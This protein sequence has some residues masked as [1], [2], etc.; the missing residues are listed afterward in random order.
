M[1]VQSE[2]VEPP[3]APQCDPQPTGKINKAAF[4][5][6]GKRRTGSG[7]ASF[8]SFRNKGATNS[9]S[10]G[11]SDNG[12]SLNGNGSAA[13]LV[14]SKT[15]DGLIGSNNDTD[16][17]RGDGLASLEVGPVR[18]LSKSL[19]FFSLLRRGSFRSSEN[20]GSGLV[21]RGRGLKG[22]FSSMRWR[23]K[24]K[25]NEGDGVEVEGHKEKDGDSTDSE[26]VKDIT[27]TLEPPPHHHQEDCGNAE[28]EPNLQAT[29]TPI[30]T[31][32]MTPPHCVAMTGPSVEPD[33]PVPYTPTDSPLRPTIQKAK[34]SISSLTPSLAS[35]PL[36]RCSTGDPPSEPSVD[37]LC[38]LLFNDVTSLKSF[39]SLT[40]CGDITAD[41]DDE[42]P[43]G[44][45]GSGTSSS[46]SGGGGGPVGAS[47]GRAVGIAS[48]TSR[49]S[50]SKPPLPSQLS[51]P[52]FSV[53]LSS[54][55]ASLPARARAPPPPQQHPAGS[56]VVAYMGGG[57]EMASPEGVDDADMQG[58]WHMLPSTGDNSPALPR[59]HQ[60]PSTTPTST[61]PPR[62]N[63]SSSHLSLASRISERKVPQ[64]KALGLSK[65]PVV[66]G[67]AVRAAKSSLPHTHGR[68][69]TS[70]GEKEPLSDE[71]YWDTPSATPTATPDESRLQRNQRMAL[72]R[73]SYSGD[74]LYDLYND[75]EE[76]EDDEEQEG[77]DDLNSTPSPSTE[78]KLS[79]SSQTSPPSS[80]S[81][82]SFRSM[83]G[84]A[85]LPRDS[86]IPVSN[87]QSS[88]PHSVSQSA[89]S[90][91][92]EAESQPPKTEAPP[93]V[94][95]RIPV[96]KVPVRRSG[97]K[98]GS[99]GT[100]HKK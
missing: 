94:R 23:R 47:V 69:P 73:D 17:Q 83:K 1:E 43:A 98:P 68:H 37:R 31:V 87:K 19:S 21:R 22:F 91:V 40:G 33:S 90:S 61:Y 14:R 92:L 95:T 60:P 84:S 53:S 46:S 20:G 2:C 12:N 3:V 67:A 16:G 7:M 5:L 99:R 50:P 70:P 27:L 56:G 78:Y 13:E 77:D 81:S 4:K 18:S 80:S 15:H 97:N 28:A 45:G 42:G 24:E 57:E 32:T 65:I 96:S 72:S 100:A 63:P 59:L 8:F 86:K 39:D 10:N 36:D 76:H 85:S 66:G 64:V 75:P 52:I 29:E 25:T 35:P 71:G 11:N 6:F 58:L 30:T 89:L 54:G 93:P 51:Q 41:A 62:S 79:P 38:S 55:H 82:S 9:G 44:N 74:Q 88:P 34:A 48:A 26:K 49:G